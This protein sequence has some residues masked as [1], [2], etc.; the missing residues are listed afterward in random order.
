MINPNAA[1]AMAK[2]I[3]LDNGH[4]Y[5]QTRRNKG[6]E[7]DCSSNTVLCLNAAGFNFSNSL[8]T[9]TLL[10]PLLAAGFVDVAKSVDLNTGKGL[11]PMDVCLRPKTKKRGGHVVLVLE[12]DGAAVLQSA[13][14]FDGVPGDSSGKE[15]CIIPIYNSPFKYVL[16]YMPAGKQ[17]SEPTRDYIY[18]TTIRGNDAGWYEME[19]HRIGYTWDRMGCDK[20]VPDEVVGPMVWEL[21]DY[22]IGQGKKI[23]VIKSEGNVAGHELR[24]YLKQCPSA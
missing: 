14:D 6:K 23:G 17:Y 3:A 11:L 1:I 24:A 2:V 5:S 18:L 21:L 4:G 19:L 10:S 20:G 15:V 8:C 13:G 7:G 16:R 22:E 9:D 12:K